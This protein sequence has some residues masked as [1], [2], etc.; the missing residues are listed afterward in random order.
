MA[1]ELGAIDLGRIV[2]EAPDALIFAD[3]EGA[4]RLWNA[5]AERLFGF[6]AA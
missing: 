1:E 3:R 5:A 4:I 6:S 2:E